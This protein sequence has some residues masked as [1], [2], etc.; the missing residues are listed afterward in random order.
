MT[1]YEE[2]DIPPTASA[3]KIR[4]SYKILVRLL[5]PD[6]CADPNL[7]RLAELQMRRLNRILDVLTDPEQ[8]RRYDIGL[9][10]AAGPLP[11]YPEAIVSPRSAGIWQRRWFVG[12]LAWLPALAGL[13]ICVGALMYYEPAGS[14]PAATPSSADL[15]A[16]SGSHLPA[17]PES[18][19]VTKQSFATEPD[20][21]ANSASQALWEPLKVSETEQA[22]RRSEHRQALAPLPVRQVLPAVPLPV[23]AAVAPSR[24]DF[25]AAPPL[26]AA[27]FDRPLSK[28]PTLA[29]NWYFIRSHRQTASPG[30]YAPE[31][32]ELRISESTGLFRGRY[33]ARYR[34]TDRAIDPEVVFQFEGPASA[35]VAQLP[36]TGPGDSGG[37]VSLRLISP[38][39]M[40]VIWIA[41]RLSLA[42]DLT[43]GTAQLV[44]QQESRN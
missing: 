11:R 15:S 41:S 22:S 13:A 36:W 25:D 9:K 28:P 20:S 43:S 17:T 4:H 16:N 39:R 33:Y 8:R 23:A 24:P 31:Y 32:I 38:D 21:E 40:E 18:A 27:R 42:L 7:K 10:A 37:K 12:L 2:L 35:P 3:E 34:V 26:S 30:M 5:H 29:G 44:R 1:Y 14:A 19:P 6:Q